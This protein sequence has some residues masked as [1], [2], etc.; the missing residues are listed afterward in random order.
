MNKSQIIKFIEKYNLSGMI[1]SVNWDIKSNTLV[2]NFSHED[3]TLLGQIKCFNF[4]VEDSKFGIFNTADLMKM[5]TAMKDDVNFKLTKT[6]DKFTS[7]LLTDGNF[8]SKYILSEPGVI[9]KPGS[10]KQFPQ[11][12]MNI[13]ITPEFISN[14]INAKNALSEASVFAI[15]SYD[16]TIEFIINYS[17]INTNNITYQVKGK[18]NVNFQPILFSTEKF[19][20]ILIANKGCDSGELNVSQ[21]GLCE[22]KFK[23]KEYESVYYLVKMQTI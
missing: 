1:E 22:L 6:N 17:N 19:K 14:F 3:K 11:F 13:E 7:I 9:P 15:K 23:T 21:Q 16:S 18:S 20:N 2:T 12:E 4:D 5:L 8:N 10:M